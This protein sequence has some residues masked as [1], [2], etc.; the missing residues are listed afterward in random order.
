M[1]ILKQIDKDYDYL[2]TKREYLEQEQEGLGLDQYIAFRW[3]IKSKEFSIFELDCVHGWNCRKIN[4][5]TCT[6]FKECELND[7]KRAENWKSANKSH[8]RNIRR[9][10]DYKS[11]QEELKQ[12]TLQE[13]SH[14]RRE[15]AYNNFES[16]AEEYFRQ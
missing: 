6:D 12:P 1:S 4:S 11:P 14:T 9:R 7:R 3:R 16:F 10:K 2:N 5:C 13:N 8:P 15:S